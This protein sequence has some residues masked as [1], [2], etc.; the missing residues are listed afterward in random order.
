MS[1]VLEWIFCP[2]CREGEGCRNENGIFTCPETKK[3]FTL[4][5]SLAAIQNS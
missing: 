3:T 4:E 5:Q 1:S 2:Y